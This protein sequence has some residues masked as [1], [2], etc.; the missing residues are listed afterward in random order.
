MNDRKLDR[1]FKYAIL[2]LGIGMFI[3]LACGL[4]EIVYETL[5]HIGV[6]R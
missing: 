4:T 5:R 1:L 6:I 3:L 2:L